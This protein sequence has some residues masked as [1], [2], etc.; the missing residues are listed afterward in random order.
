MPHNKQGL[1]IFNDIFQGVI[2]ASVSDWPRRFIFYDN[3]RK[4]EEEVSYSSAKKKV[5]AALK[6]GNYLHEARNQIDEKNKLQCGDI[7]PEFVVD[8]ILKSR[9]HQHSSSPHHQDQTV[10]VHVIRTKGWYI[11]FYF[12]DPETIFISVHQ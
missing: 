4:I 11:K 8:L 7:T 9:G 3:F 2:A 1:A 5:L 12:V 10:T 6:N